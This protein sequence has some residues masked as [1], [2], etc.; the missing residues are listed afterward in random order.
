MFLST[1]PNILRKRNPRSASS[2]ARTLPPS[3]LI[4]SLYSSSSTLS[5]TI[6]PPAWRYAFPSLNVMVRIAM[7]VSISSSAKSKR[8]TAPAYTPR[9]SLSNEEMIS[10]ALILGAP[11]TVPAGNMDRKASNLRK[12]NQQAVDGTL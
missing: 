10:I 4:V 9:R 7:H 2:N 1:N 12:A 5:K 6:P 8:P 3:L 11:D